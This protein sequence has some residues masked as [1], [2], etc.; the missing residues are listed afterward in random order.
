MKRRL[1]VV[2]ALLLVLPLAT[3]SA[4]SGDTIVIRGFGNIST[5]NPHLSS[6]GASYQAYTLLWP[7]P[8]LTDSFT[9]EPKPGLTSWTVSEDGLRYTFTIKEGAQWSDGKPIT[10]DDMIFSINVIRSDKVDTVLESNVEGIS[11]VNKIDDRTYEVVLSAPNCA[12]LSDLGEIRFLPAHKFKEDFSDFTT[13]DFNNNPDISGGPYILES[14][15]PDEGQRFR[16]NPTYWAG[17]PKIKFLVNKVIGDQAV[18]VQGIQ[19][20]D[21]DYTYFQG[22]LFQQIQDKSN[23]QW[24]AFPAVSVNFLSLNWADPSNP[25][26]AYDANKNPVQQN[27]HPIFSDPAVRQAVAMGFNIQDIIATLGPDGA[28]PLI[29]AVSPTINWAYDTKLERW[30][31]DPERAKKVLEDAGWVDSDGDGVR[32]KNG[33]RL[34]FTISYS[35]ILKHFETTALVAQDQLKQIG[36]DVKLTLVEWANY[37]TDIYFGQTYDATPM[38]NSGGTRPPDP[39]DFMT[40]LQSTQDV[41]GSGNNLASYINPEIDKLIEQARTV[42]GCALKD[43]AELYYKIQ[44][45][46]HQDVAYH[47]TYVPNI[48][49]VANKRVA[50]FNPGASW[51]FYGYTAYIHEWELK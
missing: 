24:Q 41:P 11:A 15:A 44:E 38:S 12:A 50:N 20:G 9:G 40:L 25:Q 27:P 46:A 43:R 37:L 1:I 26:P 5:F 31:Y 23:L 34:E 17:E 49:Q 51:V 32:E 29:G 48:F 10:A 33:K 2:L 36:F 14:W 7:A 6:D 21:I 3:A 16:A 39:T 22:D 8:L 13:T 19:S 35:N 28:T 42:P 4:Q 47:W 18:A 30:P 45:L